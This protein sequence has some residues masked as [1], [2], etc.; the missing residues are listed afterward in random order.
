[1]VDWGGGVS[2]SCTATHLS[3]TVANVQSF[4]LPP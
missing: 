2:D 4:N 1:V 3:G